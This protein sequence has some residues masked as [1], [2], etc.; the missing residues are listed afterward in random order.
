MCVEKPCKGVGKE[1]DHP[2]GWAALDPDLCTR[3]QVCEGTHAGEGGVCFHLPVT[4]L[5]SSLH[6]FLI[7]VV[8]NGQHE[9]NQTKG[10]EPSTQG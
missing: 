8:D 10:A 2:G 5:Q 1:G 3:P 4:D 7:H 9:C 6:L